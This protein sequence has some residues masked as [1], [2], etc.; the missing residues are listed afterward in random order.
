M[1]KFP[2][3]GLNLC[4]SSDQRYSSENTDP[5][6][7]GM[8]HKNAMISEFLAYYFVHEKCATN[9]CRIKLI[10]RTILSNIISE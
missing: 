9:A 7:T 2:G 6:L 3:Q 4:H 10:R 8:S 1:Q 5:Y